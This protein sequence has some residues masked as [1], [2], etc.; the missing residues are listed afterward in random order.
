VYTRA[1]VGPRQ[2]PLFRLP[3]AGSERR[4]S[5]HAPRPRASVARV[6][7]PPTDPISAFLDHL[8]GSGKS[9]HTLA[10][11]RLDLLQLGRFLAQTP[12]EQASPKQLRACLQWLTVDREH[13]PSSLR[14]K[15]ATYKAFFG[16]LAR[17]EAIDLDPATRI[18]YPRPQ[19]ARIHPLDT[20]EVRS[21]L[22]SAGAHSALWHLV[23]LTLL[24]T[25]IKR[26]ELVALQ[27]GDVVFDSSPGGNGFLRLRHRHQA[28]RTRLR[29]VP[30][31][32]PLQ[33]SLEAWLRELPSD[34]IRVFDLSP[35]GVDYVVEASGKLAGVRPRAKVTPQLLRDTFAVRRVTELALRERALATGGA[36][37]EELQ[38]ARDAHDLQL[39]GLLGLSPGST[40]IRRYRAAIVAP[41]EPERAIG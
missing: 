25:G 39:L 31:T 11:V 4:A 40:A 3:R 13:K 8:R 17:I 15:I 37:A 32:A 24:E 19:E 26:D 2:L 20:E 22:Q 36:T 35:R 23:V 12:L 38:A 9:Q 21:L 10:S 28:Q 7:A 29:S 5:R 34:A 41:R 1:S 27:R 6:A 18:A 16:Y 30:I 14:R 33:P